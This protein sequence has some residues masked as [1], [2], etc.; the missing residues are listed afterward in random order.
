MLKD[1][2][3]WID[4]VENTK[5][6]ERSEPDDRDGDLGFK[7]VATCKATS[8]SEAWRIFQSD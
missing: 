6:V 7:L 1:Y 3:L 8:A 5:V 2:T 4:P